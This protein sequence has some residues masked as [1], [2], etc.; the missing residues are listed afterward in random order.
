MELYVILQEVKYGAIFRMPQT[1]VQLKMDKIVT[2]HFS[3]YIW[4]TT[5]LMLVLLT[6]LSREATVNQVMD[7]HAI[8]IM[9]QTVI[10]Q[11]DICALL[12]TK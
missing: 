5:E 10:Y 2:M 6:Q 8:L 4:H 7:Y 11:L 3:D 1:I 9:D 12:V